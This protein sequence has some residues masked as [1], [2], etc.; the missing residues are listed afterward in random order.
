MALTLRAFS[1]KNDSNLTKNKP[2]VFSN[3]VNIK[4]GKSKFIKSSFTTCDYREN[5]KCPPWKL[6]AAEMTH[7]KEKKT[8]YYDDAVIR[9]YDIPIFIYLS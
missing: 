8:I 4:A 9:F 5:D 7:D 3:T 1:I 6:R 2:R